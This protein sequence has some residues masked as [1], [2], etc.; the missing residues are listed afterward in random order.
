[1]RMEFRNL[2]R[3]Y[4]YL[5]E[6][7]DENIRSVIESSSFI[8]GHIVEVLEHDLAS[9]VNVKHCI[10]CANGTDAL[11]IALMVWGIGKGD[12]VFVPDFTFFSSGEVVSAVGATPI[13]VDVSN[14]TFNMNPLSLEEQIRRVIEVGRLAP[15][16][17]I[18]VDLF[19]QPAEHYEIRRLADK[20]ELLV[21]EDGAQGFGSRINCNKA[22]SFGDIS[23]TSFFPA[24]PLGCYGDGGALF[25]DNDEWA[26]IIRSIKVH[27]KGFNKYDNVRIGMNSR[28]DAIQ[29]AVLEVKL[30]VFMTDELLKEQKIAAKYTEQLHDIVKTPSILKDFFPSWA[31][32][33]IQLPERKHRDNLQKYLKD[34]NIP[35]M[36]YYQKPMHRQKAFENNDYEYDEEM[37]QVTNKLCETVLSLPFDPYKNDEEIDLVCETIKKYMGSL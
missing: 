25:T 4:V 24:K 21:L 10:T 29:A 22:C 32:Y 18:A 8:G 27:G 35:S 34:N 26:E 17:I 36:V 31:Q 1:M 15:K 7:I 33:T 16:V 37:Y 9:C 23:T 13:F 12:A 28:L 2:K 11:Q 19:G 30:P 6:K 5:K 14:D 20:Y 3:Q